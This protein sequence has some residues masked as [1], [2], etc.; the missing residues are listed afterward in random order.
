MIAEVP[1]QVPFEMQPG[2]LPKPGNPAFP[3]NLDPDVLSRVPKLSPAQ[4]GHLRHFHNLAGQ[5]DGDWHHMG[6]CDP[7]QEVFGAY[8]YQLATMTY[9]ASA[10]HYHRLPVMSSVFRVL[11][12]QLIHKMMLRDVWG[13]WY[14]TS[15]SG[16]RIDPDI[17]EL[18]KP[19][20]DPVIKENIMFSGHL[21]LMVSLYAMLFN[22]DK[23]ERE[24]SLTFEWDPVFWG[25]GSQKYQ[26]NRASLQAAII[27]EME[28]SEWMGVCCEPN[29]V[30]VICNQ[31]PIIAMRYN[32]VR[33]GTSTAEKV[34]ENY[35]AAWL[36]RAGGF[37]RKTEDGED[38]FIEFWMVKQDVL[39]HNVL[40]VAANAW[41][42]AFMNS[43]NS[44]FVHGVF[45]RHLRCL[46]TKFPDG[47]VN[48]NN[49]KVIKQL[50]TIIPIDRGSPK[51]LT[52]SPEEFQRALSVARTDLSN[53]HMPTPMGPACPSMD[54]GF[55]VQW[56]SEVAP[57][58]D[59]DGDDILEG[60][61]CHADTY[62]NPTWEK[63][64]LYYPRRDMPLSDAEGN[65]V[66]MDPLSGNASIPYGR[67]NVR[68]G[69]KKMWDQPWAEEHHGK[70]PKIEGVDLSSGVDFLRGEWLDEHGTLVLTMKSWNDITRLVA[71]KVVN[72]PT[73]VYGVYVS[74]NLIKVHE[75][76]ERDILEI[77]LAV[78]AAEV[79]VVVLQSRLE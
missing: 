58:E 51:Q 21:L 10:A 3:A 24:A 42:S 41:A 56:V 78:G 53:Q 61:L 8:R 29:N 9:A 36:A 5:L 16:K 4:A 27:D 18:R 73:G 12:E 76:R 39:V 20:P 75:I 1:A 63:G 6:S 15:Q 77:P 65:W 33:D 48:F 35:K 25:M 69:Q 72:L 79:D 64:G 13:Y 67:L 34:L 60:L 31:F 14:L 59:Q 74:G 50:K 46:L 54:F 43:W 37:T 26:Y 66:V 17:M 11:F 57:I 32:D 2:G 38:G 49:K 30:F 71:P 70:Y 55:L 62:L 68:D 45:S 40:G 7:G 44:E 22:S 28:K 52:N 19:W 23:Y 47:R